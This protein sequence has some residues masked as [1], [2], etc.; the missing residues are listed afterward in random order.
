MVKV[1]INVCFG[2]FSVSCN[3]ARAIAEER[4]VEIKCGLPYCHHIDYERT[5]PLLVKYVEMDSK[6]ASGKL[7][8]LKVVEIPDGVEWY[9]DEYDGTEIVAENHRTWA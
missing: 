6:L 3:V 1:V 2:G 4:G 7:A 9:I 5:D 8:S